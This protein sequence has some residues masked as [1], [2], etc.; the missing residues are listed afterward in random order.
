MTSPQSIEHLNTDCT[1]VTLDRKA[2]CKAA[3]E[4]VGDPAFCNDLAV[5]HPH[6]LSAQPMFLSADHARQM[7]SILTA[8]ESVVA[9]PAYRQ[10]VLETAPPI[11]RY[12]PGPLGVFMGYDFH[13]GLTGPRLIEI[14]TN[15]GGALLNAC[16]LQAQR[17]CCSAMFS[18]PSSQDPA[19]IRSRFVADFHAEWNRQGRTTPLRTVAI[20][21]HAPTEQYLYPEFVIFQ[22]LLEA[23]GIHAIIA[24]PTECAHHDAA[25]WHN[26]RKIDLVYNRLTDFELATPQT[27]SLREAYLADDVSVTPNPRAHA[28]YANK[29]NLATLTNPT[30]LRQ[31]GVP[32]PT[33]AT[34]NAGI[35]RT[36][37]ITD[38]N[39]AA[40]WATRKT[41]FFKPTAGYGGKATYRGDKITHKVWA[42]I[43]TSNYVA[44]DLVPPSTRMIAIDGQLQN[45]KADLRAYTYAGEIRLL[46][47]RLYQGQ[48]TNFRTPGGGFAPVFVSDQSAECRCD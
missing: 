6:L 27:R 4:I 9:L 47:A 23:N 19:A 43:A 24:D 36:Q 33:I 48:T 37:R 38:A 44:Q 39:R 31:W 25:L 17:I 3:E 2:L 34:L 18:S 30:L 22:R 35:P 28:L 12:E 42:E 5:S 13:L 26:G 16:L 41:L 20:L 10:T 29:A 15:A 14:N 46:A 1:C 32:E 11:A 45:L 21:D 8:I 40:L 7:Q